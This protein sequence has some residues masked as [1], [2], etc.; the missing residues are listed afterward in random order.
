MK[1]FN[2][3]KTCVLFVQLGVNQ[4]LRSTP[5]LFAHVAP[6]SSLGS[7]CHLLPWILQCTVVSKAFF[8]RGVFGSQI[9]RQNRMVGYALVNGVWGYIW[10]PYAASISSFIQDPDSTMIVTDDC[11]GCKHVSP[12]QLAM[13]MKI[14]DLEPWQDT[15]P[16][17]VLFQESPCSMQLCSLLDNLLSP[18]L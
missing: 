9:K 10:N 13:A 3:L 5:C 17:H 12:S 11:N 18:D 2:T 15:S 16:F 6:S 1:T 4:I 7:F 14:C 8:L